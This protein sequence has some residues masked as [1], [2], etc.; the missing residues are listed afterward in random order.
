MNICSIV[1]SL[2]SLLNYQIVNKS[3]IIASDSIVNYLRDGGPGFCSFQ[4]QKFFTHL[5]QTCSE[6]HPVS[7]PIGDLFRGNKAAGP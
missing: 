2:Y 7:C 6:T 4:A 5:Y 3:K 1:N